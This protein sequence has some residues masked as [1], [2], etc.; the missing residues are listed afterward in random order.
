[1]VPL[2]GA[3]TVVLP[4]MTTET[5]PLISTPPTV[6]EAGA[7]N[8][9]EPLRTVNASPLTDRTLVPEDVTVMLPITR[10]SPLLSVNWPSDAENLPSSATETWQLEVEVKE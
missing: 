3:D 1:M 9:R 10:V 8:V 7:E 2:A 6:N 5:A 4:E